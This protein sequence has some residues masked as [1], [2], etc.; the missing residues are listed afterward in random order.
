M[1]CRSNSANE[2]CDLYLQ[3]VIPHFWVLLSSIKR[4]RTSNI[5][6]GKSCSEAPPMV[7]EFQKE[8]PPPSGVGVRSLEQQQRKLGIW[9]NLLAPGFF[10]V[11]KATKMKIYTWILLF[12]PPIQLGEMILKHGQHG[13]RSKAYKPPWSDWGREFPGGELFGMKMVWRLKASLKL[14]YQYISLIS[15]EK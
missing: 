5:I 3:H 6:H 1:Q 12:P 10:C 4:P 2:C 9:K 7:M 14:T 15:P 11:S 8:G 13:A